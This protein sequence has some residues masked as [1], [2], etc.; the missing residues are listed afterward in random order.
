MNCTEYG[1]WVSRYVDEDLEG[2][3]LE[4]F[5]AH[6]SECAECRKEVGA[7]ERLRGWFQA[8][9]SLQGIPEIRGEWGL[10]DLLQ[11]EESSDAVDCP[12]PLSEKI[13]HEASEDKKARSRGTAW[14]KRTL[15]PFPMPTPRLVRFALPLLVVSVVA[16]WLYM[17]KT[18]NLIDVR[19]LQPSQVTTVMFPEEKAHYEVDLFVMQHSTHQPWA[20][21]GD[22]FP[23]IELASG[24]SR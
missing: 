13:G 14:I 5:L 1:P 9:D 10:A 16:A 18:S 20:D 3:D 22:E 17:R 4:A 19:E 8:A 7:T 24:S 21:L 2:K 15:F 23:M 6:L 12:E 11:Q